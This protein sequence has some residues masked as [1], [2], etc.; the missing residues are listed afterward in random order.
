LEVLGLSHESASSYVTIQSLGIFME[1]KQPYLWMP[2]LF[3]S[4]QKCGEIGKS[5]KI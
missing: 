3:V 5:K 1:D 4:S 2:V